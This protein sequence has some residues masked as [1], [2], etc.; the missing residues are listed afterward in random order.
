MKRKLIICIFIQHFL[1]VLVLASTPLVKNDDFCDDMALGTDEKR[2]AACTFLPNL[3]LTF[4]CSG[5]NKTSIPLSRI[6]DSVCDCCDGSD[7]L[8]GA[9]QNTCEQQKLD[10]KVAVS[11]VLY[12]SVDNYYLQKPNM[13]LLCCKMS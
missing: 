1:L 6:H 11:N 10:A 9:C 7:E 4:P 8:E 3:K 12:I 5:D 13:S 2:S